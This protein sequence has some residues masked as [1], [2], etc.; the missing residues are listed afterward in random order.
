MKLKIKKGK[1]GKSQ[2]IIL[3]IGDPRKY[4]E[5]MIAKCLIYIYL[6]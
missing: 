1:N 4:Y 5:Y 3:L 6:F 2:F